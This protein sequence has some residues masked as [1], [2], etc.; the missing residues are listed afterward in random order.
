MSR[1]ARSL[2]CLGLAAAWLAALTACDAASDG[3]SVGADADGGGGADLAVPADDDGGPSADVLPDGGAPV[4]C[5]TDQLCEGQ[6][7]GLGACEVAG[8]RDGACVA[9]A[10]PEG[11][12]CDDGNACTAGDICRAGVCA[13]VDR[14]T[15][16]REDADCA[17][18]EDG[19]PCN[20]TLRCE[21]PL[22]ALDDAS[23]VSCPAAEAC[24]SWTCRPETGTCEAVPDHLGRPCEGEGACEDGA[25]RC[26]ADGECACER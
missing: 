19:D 3:R 20:G 23:I 18:F 15:I 22:C 5:V 2:A 11:T 8:C 12:P 13:G 4:G 6:L 25:F 10:A 14:C 26:R 1:S 7:T 9:V 17:A 16:C 21:S 24:R